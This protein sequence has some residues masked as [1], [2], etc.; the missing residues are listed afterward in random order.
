VPYIVAA[1]F[2]VSK[3]CDVPRVPGSLSALRSNLSPISL[4]FCAIE[5]LTS[6]DAA[7]LIKNTRYNYIAITSKLQIN[8]LFQY[9]YSLRDIAANLSVFT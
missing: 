2:L 6:A 7:E 1:Q 3:T 8:I 5:H 4:R 9:Y